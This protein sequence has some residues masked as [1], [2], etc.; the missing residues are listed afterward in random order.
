[1]HSI[2]WILPILG[3]VLA[4]IAVTRTIILQARSKDQQWDTT[5]LPVI[6]DPI[7][8][9]QR[10]AEAVTYA[11]IAAPDWSET[12]FTTFNDFHTFLHANYPQ[13]FSKLEVLDAGPH[14]IVLRWPG[15][16]TTLLPAL[17][18][19]HQ[20]VVPASSPD[21]WT[22]P[23]FSKQIAEG[24]VWGRGSFDAKGQLVAIMEAL[25]TLV[26]NSHKPKR[27]WY[28]AFGCDE[29]IRGSHGAATI[30]QYFK[31]QHLSFAF[32]LDEGG[33][34]AEGFIPS[35]PH[36]VAVIGIAEK[37]DVNVKLTCIREGGHSSSP[38]NPTALGILGRAIWRLES[39]LPPVIMTAP[40]RLMLTTLGLQAPFLLALP[41]L[42]LWLFKPLIALAFRTSPTMNALL[43]NTVAVTMA[44][45]SEAPNVI[46][47]QAEAV[48]NLRLVP[49]QSAQQALAWV[50]RRINDTRVTS[51]VMERTLRS[52]CSSIDGPEF[53]LLTR[54]I[55][56]VFPASIPT[57][58]LMTGGTDAIWYEPMSRQVYRFTPAC[59]NTK[60]LHRMHNRDE[61]F[62]VENLKKATQFYIT[63]ISLDTEILS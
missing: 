5:D 43:R 42:N 20:D 47:N 41:L 6:Q 10:L 57:P 17:L 8:A 16:D 23:P 52:E 33:V 4:L 34:V 53:T 32:V 55:K 26:E 12:D 22:Y 58:Y 3:V 14:N 50:N 25:E 31:S 44:Q 39:K 59:M 9:A 56:R 60:E 40:V 46:A 2:L 54:A 61:R 18:L 7:Q 28:I 21:E 48:A 24:Y 11:T 62:S 38:D 15:S 30:A 19:A 63:L 35:L 36:P 29:E 1:M 51:T 27:T 45:G 49:G 37:G 13:T